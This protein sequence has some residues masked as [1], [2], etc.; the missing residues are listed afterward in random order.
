MEIYE[1]TAKDKSSRRTI[2]RTLVDDLEVR[3]EFL[4][5]YLKGIYVTAYFIPKTEFTVVDLSSKSGSSLLLY[6]LRYKNK[7]AKMIRDGDR[8]IAEWKKE[9]GNAERDPADSPIIMSAA[10]RAKALYM[11]TEEIW[12]SIP[13][14]KRFFY[15]S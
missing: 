10:K 9:D 12:Q 13:D 3:G 1:I 15:K 5:L 2:N 7:V 4:R 14:I 6:Y 11:A 8:M